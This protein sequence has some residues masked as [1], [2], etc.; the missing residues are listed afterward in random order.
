MTT[1]AGSSVFFKPG[2]HPAAQVLLPTPERT[3]AFITGRP[4]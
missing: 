2:N 3:L 1:T 4:A